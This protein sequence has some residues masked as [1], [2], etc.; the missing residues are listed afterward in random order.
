MVTNVIVP[1]K[2]LPMMIHGDHMM[3]QRTTTAD[4]TI[5]G[6]LYLAQI[7]HMAYYPFHDSDSGFITVGDDTA[8]GLLFVGREIHRTERR[9]TWTML[10][11]PLDMTLP[12]GSPLGADPLTIGASWRFPYEICDAVVRTIQHHPTSSFTVNWSETDEVC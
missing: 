1:T 7:N 2:I 6:H 11:R 10:F 9:A 5:H 8:R 12:I 3:S 4:R